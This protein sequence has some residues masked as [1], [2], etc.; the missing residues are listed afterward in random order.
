L[1]NQFRPL[2]DGILLPGGSAKINS[3]FEN[4][5]APGFRGSTRIGGGR[6]FGD[7]IPRS[8]LSWEA[9]G[10]G[11]SAVFPFRNQKAHMLWSKAQF[12]PFR[13]AVEEGAWMP[14]KTSRGLPGTCPVLG[15]FGR[16]G[17]PSR[18]SSHCK[19]P[20]S[21]KFS[22]PEVGVFARDLPHPSRRIPVGEKSPGNLGGFLQIRPGKNWHRV[23]L[24]AWGKP[25]MALG[26]VGGKQTKSLSV[27][28]RALP[29]LVPG[30][31]VVF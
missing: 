30:G 29:A 25:L 21:A 5:L 31:I 23:C 11:I 4:Q 3:N 26:I 14:C 10:V 20:C 15:R 9:Q 6:A 24:R 19:S 13:L 22:K 12:W 2:R 16:R 17:R 8:V 28:K 7:F 1:S 18:F 27:E